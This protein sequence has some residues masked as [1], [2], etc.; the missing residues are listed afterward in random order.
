MQIDLLYFEGCPSWQI[1]LDNLNAALIAEGIQ[2]KIHLVNVETN[3]QAE[4]L[5]FLGS[6]TFQIDGVDL[7]PEERTNY[8]LSCRVYATPKGIQGS[9][10]VDMLRQKLGSISR[11][12]TWNGNI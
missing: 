2:A 3:S 4:H 9:P 5:K 12:R 1:G 7:W 11:D 8:I 6:P 10:T